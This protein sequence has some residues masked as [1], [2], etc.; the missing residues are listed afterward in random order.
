MG[1]GSTRSKR[2]G[3]WWLSNI[4]VLEHSRARPCAELLIGASG[5]GGGLAPPHPSNP[6]SAVGNS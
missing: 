1:L 5:G 6:F 3:G 4:E 2:N